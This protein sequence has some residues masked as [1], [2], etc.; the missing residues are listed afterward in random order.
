MK[1]R[2]KTL[3]EQTLEDA[4]R[5]M[6]ATEEGRVVFRHLLDQTGFL[7]PVCGPNG[8]GGFTSG[9]ETFWRDGRRSIGMALIERLN[10]I[11]P[12]A[13]AGLLEEC[14]RQVENERATHQQR[15]KESD[16]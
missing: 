7:A 16:E 5:A 6:L 14:A 8:N 9:S 10:S 4:Y 3:Q 1:Q 11:T 2:K 13:F 12:Y 15:P